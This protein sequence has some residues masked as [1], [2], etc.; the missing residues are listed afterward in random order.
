MNDIHGKAGPGT[1][2]LSF[3]ENGKVMWP[4]KEDGTNHPVSVLAL[5]DNKV[6]FCEELIG[7]PVRLWRLNED[8]TTDKKFGVDGVVEV[9]IPV[10]GGQNF[11]GGAKL[12]P[13]PSGGYL[14]TVSIPSSGVFLIRMDTSGQ[15]VQSFGDRGTLK[16]YD[17][18]LVGEEAGGSAPGSKHDNGAQPDAQSEGA[19]KGMVL[20]QP[21]GKIVLVHRNFTFDFGVLIRL[22]PDGSFDCSLN[23]SGYIQLNIEREGVK[24]DRFFPNAVVRQSDGKLLVCGSAENYSGSDS[25]IARYESNGQ[26]D[27]GFSGGAV[28]PYTRPDSG[29]YNRLYDICV[30]ESDGAIISVGNVHLGGGRYQGIMIVLNYNGSFNLVFNNGKL[31]VVD[32]LP[33]MTPRRCSLQGDAITVSGFGRPDT[34][35]F[36]VRYLFSGLLDKKFNEQGW[37]EIDFNRYTV[38]NDMTIMKDSRVVISAASHFGDDPG[39]M[40]R[41]LA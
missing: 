29:H 9:H 10:V 11:R 18:E 8:G 36:I 40:A 37:V 19:A 27:K 38:L 24:Y 1:P 21:D 26:L 32:M 12:S 13:C 14:Y 41:Y 23:G 30:R 34:P 25:F 31:L 28:F 15:L 4:N 20:I 22:N 7:N 35:S 6:L 2:D 33:S 3:G 5:P 39:W 16:I 17:S